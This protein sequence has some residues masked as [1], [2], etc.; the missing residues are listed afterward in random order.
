MKFL[1][2]SAVVAIVFTPTAG[3]AAVPCAQLI[4]FGI[5]AKQ[6]PAGTSVAK[7]LP[8]RVGRFV[9]EPIAGDVLVPMNEDFNITYRSGSDSVFIGLSRPGA[10]ADLKEAVGTSRQDA[11]SDKS[12]NRQ[13]EI[14]CVTS[15]P[16]FYKIPDFI[17]WTRGPYFLYADA[18]SPAVLIDFMTAFPY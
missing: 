17:S 1:A 3:F 11:V 16:F 5:A 2:A 14:Y 9:R 8:A 4:P 10:V 18:S 13:G 12:I 7:I 6:Q 15:A